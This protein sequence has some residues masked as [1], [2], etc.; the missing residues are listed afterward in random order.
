MFLRCVDLSLQTAIVWDK[1]NRSRGSQRRT[2]HLNSRFSFMLAALVFAGFAADSRACSTAAWIPGVGGADGVVFAD[3]PVTVSRYEGVCAL[4][5]AGQGWVQSNSASDQ[6]YIARFYVLLDNLSGAGNTV[7]FRGYSDDAATGSLYEVRY[8]GSDF[9]FDVGG[10]TASEPSKPGWNLVE[11]DWTSNGSMAFW[12]NADSRSEPAS[13]SVTAGSGTVEAVRL[14][15]PD[16]LGGFGGFLAVDAF[17]SHRATPVGPLLVGDA[18]ADGV[19]NSADIDAIRDEFF[20][21]GLS[22]GTP[23]CNEDGAVDSGDTICVINEA[24]GG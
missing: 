19:V 2:M 13:G 14:G 11:I 17:E 22:T 16:G 4:K 6:R 3:S 20:E 7:I 1:H 8:D 24:N 21:N 10:V 9:V 18:N 15:M 23:D 5:V 12:V